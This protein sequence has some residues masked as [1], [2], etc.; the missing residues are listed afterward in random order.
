M[1]KTL[2][3]PAQVADSLQVN[4]RTVTR[5]LRDRYL[6][7][8]KLGKEWRISSQDLQ[9]FVERQS[10]SPESRA[11]N[12]HSGVSLQSQS[13]QS[14]QTARSAFDGLRLGDRHGAAKLR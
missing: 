5:W 10:N 4:E 7:G 8:Y 14:A 6:R 2:L 9:H 1:E 11:D 13:A 12:G 3:T